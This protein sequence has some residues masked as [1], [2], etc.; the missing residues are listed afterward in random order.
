MKNSGFLLD[1]ASKT[2]LPLQVRQQVDETE[3]IMRRIADY[4]ITHPRKGRPKGRRSYKPVP[5]FVA[6]TDDKLDEL[7]LLHAQAMGPRTRGNKRHGQSALYAD[8]VTFF[9]GIKQGGEKITVSK[10]LAKRLVTPAF[11]EILRRHGYINNY[12][13][14]AQQRSVIGAQ[15]ESQLRRASDTVSGKLRRRSGNPGA[16]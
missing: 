15:L 1:E 13:L 5:V 9:V 2:Q 7:M 6:D 11:I 4:L 10:V 12:S 8:L 14:T 16:F 3:Q